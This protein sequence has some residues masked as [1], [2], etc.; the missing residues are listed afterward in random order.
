MKKYYLILIFISFISGKVQSQTD[1]VS[2][3]VI[4]KIAENFEKQ[5]RLYPQEKLYTQIDKPYCVAGE[6][7]WFRTYLTD[8]STNIPNSISRYVYAE[9]IDPMDSVISRVKVRPVHGAYHGHISLPEDMAEGEYQL[10]FYTRFMESFGDDYFFKRSVRIGDPLTALYRTES[11]FSYENEKKLSVKLRITDIKENTFI[12]PD[13]VEIMDE[14]GNLKPVKVKDDYTIDFSLKVPSKKKVLFVKYDYKGKFHKEYIAIPSRPDFEVSFLPEGGYNIAGTVNRIAFKALNSDGLGEDIEGILINQRGDTLDSFRSTHLGM[15]LL[16]LNS[17]IDSVFYTICKNNAGL[18]KKYRIPSAT[19]EQVAL[20]VNSLSNKFHLSLRVSKEKLLN[21]DYYVVIQCRGHILNTFKWN[22]EKTF[23]TILKNS[24]PSGVIQILLVD[25][26]MNPVSERLVFNVNKSEQTGIEFITDKS[27]YAGREQVKGSIKLKEFE[28]NGQVAGLS[29]SVTDD[30]DVKTDTCVNI[31]SSLLLTSE[32]KGHVESPA[33]YFSGDIRD[34]LL[35][36]DLLMMTQGWS[37]YNVGKVLKGDLEKPNGYLELG[38]YL[39]GTVKGGFFMNKKSDGYPVTLISLQNNIFREALTDKDGR[40]H[41]QG[42]EAPD[43]TTFIIQGLTKKGGGRV[44]LLID[45]EVFPDNKFSLPLS[46]VENRSLFEKYMK[47]ADENFLLANGMRMIYLKDIEI[48]GRKNMDDNKERSVYSSNMNIRKSYK[49]IEK[50]SFTNVV[51]LL[52]LFAG[53]QVLPNK[54]SIRGGEKTL[55]L[56][57]GIQYEMDMLY[58]IPVSDIDEVEIMKDGTA[59]ILGGRGSDGVIMITTKR[60]E[61]NLKNEDKFNI[62]SIT[63]LGYQVTKEFYSPQYE[64][65]EQR[66]AVEPDLRTTVY[67]NPD[68]KTNKSGTA[69]INFYTADASTTY[70]VVIEGITSGGSLI[71]SVHKISRKD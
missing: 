39:S 64:T 56:V 33:H 23:V 41:L 68:I 6:N 32:L 46:T 8:A 5:L 20:S 35:N 58:S 45:K 66:S 26:N 60:G 62:K 59:A 47:K 9:L 69:D 11:D 48:L 28:N 49:E 51:Q 52:N 1:D 37:R 15:G 22:E 30:K 44:E 57:D 25:R 50:Y 61:I 40:F 55:I 31:L 3:S 18:E 70:S 4:T 29:V 19:A 63:P 36:I 53:V 24:L 14:N 34:K 54:I 10:R 12:Q 7:I 67:W 21:N 17:Q 27:N 13:R 42:F 43:S 16:I 71:H 38:Q 65:N 2:D